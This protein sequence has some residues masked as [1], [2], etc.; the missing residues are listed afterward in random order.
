MSDLINV[1]HDELNNK[2][3]IILCANEGI[4]FDQYTLFSKVIDKFTSTSFIPRSFK[5]KFMLVLRNL[6]ITNNDVK[7]IKKNNVYNVVYNSPN[8]I[9]IKD[10]NY[11][12]MWLNIHDFNAYIIDSNLYSEF[13]YKDIESGDTL[14]HNILGG[15]DY[16]TV[17]RLINSNSIDY[18][19]KNNFDKT[20]IECINDIKVASL[21]ISDLNLRINNLESRI[22][23][24]ETKDYFEDCSIYNFLKLKLNAFIKKYYTLI[25]LVFLVI[26]SNLFRFI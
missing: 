14:Y 25:F 3:M 7:I 19:V 6:M 5:C 23:N 10:S 12:N 24:L 9:E 1:T 20:P 2:I 21:V 26:I 13:G 17:K 11:D 15:N 16:I 8:D 22:K 4:I 18:N